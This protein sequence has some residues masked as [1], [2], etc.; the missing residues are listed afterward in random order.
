MLRGRH[1]FLNPHHLSHVERRGVGDLLGMCH[2]GLMAATAVIGLGGR[3]VMAASDGPAISILKDM[4][5]GCRC[6]I[7]WRVAPEDEGGG[8]GGDEGWLEWW[9]VELWG[10]G[11]AEVEAGGGAEH[12]REGEGESDQEGKGQARERTHGKS[13]C[14]PKEAT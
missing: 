4:R 6:T 12:D 5:R 7:D 1:E 9:W 11:E 8:E 14:A 2:L 3:R 13:S 10:S